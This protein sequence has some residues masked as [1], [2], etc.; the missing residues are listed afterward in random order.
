MSKLFITPEFYKK[1]VEDANVKSVL[2]LYGYS[3]RE[4]FLKEIIKFLNS[5]YSFLNIDDVCLMTQSEANYYSMYNGYVKGT[6]GEYSEFLVSFSDIYTKEGNTVISQQVM[7]MLREKISDSLNFLYNKKIKKV[8]LLTSHKSTTM[9]IA[10]NAIK[11]DSRGSTLQLLVKC[12]NTLGFDVYPFIPVLNPDYNSSFST[13]K[14][15]CDN[16]EYITGQNSGNLQHKNIRLEGN[17]VVGSFAQKPKGQDEKY[18][19]IRYLTAIFLNNHNTYDVSDAYTKSE[20]SAMMTMLYDF[21]NYVQ[22]NDIVYHSEKGLTD[23]EF[24]S[25]LK[26]EDEFIKKLAK[27]AEQYGEEGV[28]TVTSTVRLAE[29]QTELRRRLIEKEG[30]KCL[31]CGTTNEELLVAS[32]IKP[33]SECDIFGK[34]DIENAFLLCAGHDKL[35]DRCLI[36]FSFIDGQIM[37][38]NKLT[39]EEKEIYN[40][41]ES[42]KLPAEMLTTKRVEYLM[43]HN[44]EF[45]KKNNE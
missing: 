1:L 42:Y 21:A 32:H 15:L 40:L 35:F 22:T 25:L 3:S 20:K 38:S 24:I 19:A 17:K 8:F 44:D 16:I 41:D 6:L 18:F 14:E 28:R 43:W 33:A 30:C 13:V 45:E 2:K 36:S 11:E 9:N 39:A 23:A 34:A 12:L 37:I 10:S 4:V 27:L 7:P 29:V 26:K 31:L 5:K